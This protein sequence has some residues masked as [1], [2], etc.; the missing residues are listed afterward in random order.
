MKPEQRITLLTL[1]VADL[2]AARHF[3][4]DIFGWEA[5][6][7]SNEAIRFYP[8]PGGLHLSVYGREALAED[9]EVSA[10]GSGFRGFSLAYNT[11]SQQEVDDI[12]ANLATKGV[13]IVKKARQVFWGGY[14]G[15]IADPDG[16]LWEIAFNPHLIPA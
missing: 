7:A 5:S 11:R 2:A 16:H 6:P 8:L 4:E 12:M 9:A 3:Y 1:G 13:R 14:S 10:T 15:Y